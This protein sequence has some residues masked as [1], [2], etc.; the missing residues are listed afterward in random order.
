MKRKKKTRK[1]ALPADYGDATPEQ[2]AKA[3]LRHR[4][5]PASDGGEGV[6]PVCRPAMPERCRETESSV[7]S[8]GA[9]RGSLSGLRGSSSS[10]LICCWNGLRLVFEV[11]E[12]NSGSNGGS[13]E[14]GCQDR[15]KLQ[16]MV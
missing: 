2:V 1:K 11:P 8:F 14:N 12:L 6:S 15:P 13:A 4:R 7:G 5:R 16:N 10:M 9:L 3:F